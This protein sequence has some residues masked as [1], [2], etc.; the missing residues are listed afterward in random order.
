[1]K[2]KN[3]HE[4]EEKVDVHFGPN[5]GSTTL[6]L[7]RLRCAGRPKGSLSTAACLT[8]CVLLHRLHPKVLNQAGSGEVFLPVVGCWD[9]TPALVSLLR[10][11][12]WVGAGGPALRRLGVAVGGVGE[13]LLQQPERAGV[14]KG[15]GRGLHVV[16]GGE[17]R[18][19][20]GVQTLG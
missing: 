6:W 20:G 15:W 12:G 9:Y 10:S 1:M 19:C 16:D 5:T 17:L 18:D 3:S 2:Q 13:P 11:R 14:R 4:P 7:Q 8:A